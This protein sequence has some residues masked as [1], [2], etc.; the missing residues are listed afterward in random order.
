[1]IEA[2]QEPRDA[3]GTWSHE[4]L[5]VAASRGLLKQIGP[6]NS[7]FVASA[8]RKLYRARLVA[9]YAPQMRVEKTDAIAAVVLAQQTRRV[10]E[11]CI[12]SV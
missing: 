2:G 12:W 3:L 9:D 7:R 8:I 11:Q 5:P 4:T 10:M 6:E 1:M